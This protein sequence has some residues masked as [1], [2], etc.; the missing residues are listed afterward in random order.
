ML[1]TTTE[2]HGHPGPLEE[3]SLD[4]E[5]LLAMP[6][7]PVGSEGYT[8]ET[9]SSTHCN[10]LEL[11]SPA[12]SLASTGGGSVYTD[13][14]GVEAPSPHSPLLVASTFRDLPQFSPVNSH[15]NKNSSPEFSSGWS[16]SPSSY[17]STPTTND[18]STNAPFSSDVRIDVGEF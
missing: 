12:A 3:A 9:S 18:I 2:V 10:R 14:L 15:D 11:N 4:F 1:D 13:Q 5:S 7:S 8:S 6:T 16:A 17:I